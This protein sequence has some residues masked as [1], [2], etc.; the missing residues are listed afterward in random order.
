MFPFVYFQVDHFLKSCKSK[1]WIWQ[2]K[3]RSSFQW[4]LHIIFWCLLQ[5]QHRC[6]SLVLTLFLP[7]ILYM[8][9]PNQYPVH[10]HVPT[11]CICM[12]MRQ[13]YTIP[14]T[15]ISSQHWWM[16][17]S[18]VKFE[19]HCP[20]NVWNMQLA[21]TKECLGKAKSVSLFLKNYHKWKKLSLYC[22][23]FLINMLN[24]DFVEVIFFSKNI[25]TPPTKSC[26]VQA[27]HHAP[28]EISVR[29]PTFL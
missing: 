19:C 3:N 7:Y 9:S 24:D 17:G 25:H 14:Y 29:L 8:M 12:S 21:D 23:C 22:S 18:L 28:F 13:Q 16:E 2:M 11:H 26:L 5:E 20:Q 4:W 15:D 10:Q 6:L 27:P 1:F